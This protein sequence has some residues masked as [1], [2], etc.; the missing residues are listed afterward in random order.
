MWHMD[1]GD[2]SK[3]TDCGCDLLTVSHNHPV[4]GFV[5]AM[6][7]VRRADGT[8]VFICWRF[9]GKRYKAR[10]MKAC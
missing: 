4:L 1:M 2:S 6:Q 8:P 9:A 7:F 5:A 10:Q 3:C